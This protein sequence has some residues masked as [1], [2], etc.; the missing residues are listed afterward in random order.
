MNF[1]VDSHAAVWWMDDPNRLAPA[2]RDAIADG[3]NLVYLSAASVWE[4][5]L[6]MARGKLR[7]PATY[8]DRLRA[9]GFSFLD[10]S[11][12]HA[13]RA[14]FLP[15]H[16]ADPFDRLLIAQAQIEGLV[17]V[18]RDEDLHAYGVPVLRA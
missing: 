2:A 7:L 4:I 9:D 12:S 14:P 1:L 13:Q 5:G 6:K 3:R 16:H 8:V 15:P 17:L 10:V 11:V 18:T